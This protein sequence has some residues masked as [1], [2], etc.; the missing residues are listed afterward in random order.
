MRKTGRIACRTEGFCLKSTDN[1]ENVED[2]RQNVQYFDKNL[3]NSPK[4]V[5]HF[6]LNL[7]TFRI[8]LFYKRGTGGNWDGNVAGLHR[9]CTDGGLV[10]G[11]AILP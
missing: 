2:L 10:S 9:F 8:A 11:A 7:Q 5:E 6:P 1:Q 4:N 3:L